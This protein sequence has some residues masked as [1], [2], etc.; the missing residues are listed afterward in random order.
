MPG[1]SVRSLLG[2][3]DLLNSTIQFAILTGQRTQQCGSRLF[4][5][6]RTAVQTLARLQV[7]DLRLQ[8]AQAIC[9][10]APLFGNVAQTGCHQ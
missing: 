1:G 3:I 6:C 2:L 10:L 8:L 4:W 9:R 5:Q 7:V